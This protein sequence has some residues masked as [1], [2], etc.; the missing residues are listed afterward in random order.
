MQ[1]PDIHRPAALPSRTRRDSA[2]AAIA[3]AIAQVQQEVPRLIEE[4]HAIVGVDISCGRPTIQLMATARLGALAEAG[5]AA[6]WMCGYDQTGY[7]RKGQLI[8]RACR[9]IW[10]ERGH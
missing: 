8:R 7:Y 3:A 6:Y 1:I 2:N 9:V 4:G 10:I 5:E